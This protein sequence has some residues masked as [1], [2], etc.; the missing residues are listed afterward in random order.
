MNTIDQNIILVNDSAGG[1]TYGPSTASKAWGSRGCPLIPRAI[2]KRLATTAL[3][4]ELR[5]VLGLGSTFGELDSGFIERQHLDELP[6]PTRRLVQRQIIKPSIL[7]LSDVVL[8]AGLPLAWFETLSIGGRARNAVARAF[9][10]RGEEKNL[11]SPILVSEFSK[12]RSVGTMTMIEL[13]CVIESAETPTAGPTNLN[14]PSPSLR[15]V[16]TVNDRW[17]AEKS[18][19]NRLASISPLMEQIANFA[20]WSQA[21]K[22]ATT[23]QEAI[24]EVVADPNAAER[25][26][27]TFKVPLARIATRPPHPY[28]LI[29]AWTH[30]LSD[31]EAEVFVRRISTNEKQTLETIATRFELTRERIRQIESQVKRKFREFLASDDAEPIRWRAATLSDIVAAAAPINAIERLIVAPDDANDYG[32]AL[33]EFAGLCA[34]DG[35]WVISKDLRVTDVNRNILAHADEFGR[36]DRENVATEL[37]TAGVNPLFQSEWIAKEPAIREFNGELV[38]WGKSAKDRLVFAL[39]DLNHEASVDELLAH[40]EEDISRGY[41]LNAL[42]ADDRVVR[43]GRS[44]Y[45]LKSWGLIEYKGI[46]DAIRYFISASSRPVN[47]EDACVEISKRFEVSE[48]SVRL[49]MD[50]PMFVIEGSFV[51]LRLEDEPF[52]F[53]YKPVR[54]TRGVFALGSGRVS[55]VL[56]VDEDM[57][58]GSG[59]M[60]PNAAGGVLK[61]EV[62]DEIELTSDE[63]E[64]IALT[65]PASSNLGPSMGSTR[66]FAERLGARLED[67]LTV[68]MDLDRRSVE[69]RLTRSDAVVQSWDFVAHLTGLNAEAGLAGLAEGLNCTQGEVR[70]ILR[71]RGDLLLLEAIPGSPTSAKLADALGEL[72]NQISRTTG[73]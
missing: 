22:G 71:K 41:A 56:T 59:R 54:E 31:L 16:A 3:P 20:S 32:V 50:A 49:Y 17:D 18:L 13:L 51:R 9:L 73:V 34:T 62:G 45:A 5:R 53:D 57:L 12:H 64:T 15:E 72:R 69:T 44:R 24:L 4:L 1:V 58:R 52:R 40:L 42:A 14:D 55:V 67:H 39:A 19:Q 63:G 26:K 21:E 36:L 43:V 38:V 60:L 7:Q 29:E 30:R 8:P 70:A 37:T 35:D 47:I 61:I 27:E 2:R 23:F 10:A 33:L 6:K 25:W 65:Y 46:A 11:E 66:I 48:G 28:V 68:I